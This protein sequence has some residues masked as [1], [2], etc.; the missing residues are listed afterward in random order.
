MPPGF[1][2]ELLNGAYRLR[3]APRLWYVQANIVLLEAGPEELQTANA[4]FALRAPTTRENLG[5][6]VLHVG[7]ACVSGEGPLWETARNHIRNQCTL[8]TYEY[9]TF[10]FLG[11]QCHQHK[12]YTIQLHQTGYV[13][14]L[15]RV[16]SSHARRGRSGDKLTEK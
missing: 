8:G 13:T 11:R 7:D 2:L 1:L 15:D 5:M 10:T 12:D 3:G 16:Y 14:A 6:L 4:C 9:G